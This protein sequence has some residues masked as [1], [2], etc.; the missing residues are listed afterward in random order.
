MPMRTD[1]PLL[2]IYKTVLTLY[3]FYSLPG[4]WASRLVGT[5]LYSPETPKRLEIG[6]YGSK[7]QKTTR[8]NHAYAPFSTFQKEIFDL[9]RGDFRE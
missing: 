5:S 8:K 4:R 1:N 6:Q 9:R 2:Y 3:G 7:K